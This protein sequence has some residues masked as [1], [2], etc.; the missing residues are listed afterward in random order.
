MCARRIAVLLPPSKG[1]AN[2]DTAASSLSYAQTL[3]GKDPLARPRRVVLDALL[4]SHATL[5][6]P[7]KMRLYGVGETAVVAAGQQHAALS[8]A[9]TRPARE[10][11][12]GVIYTN[13]GLGN[14][15]Y[16]HP[17]VAVLIVSAVLGVVELDT[18]IPNY[19]VEFGAQLPPVG[20]LSRFWA[21]ACRDYLLQ[22][23]AGLEVWNLLPNEH[24]GILGGC[25]E[26]LN[27]IDVRFVTPSGARANTA[28]SKVAKGHMVATLR[29][30]GPLDSK[31]FAALNPLAPGW[32][33][34]AEGQTLTGVCHL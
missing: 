7:A 17:D 19:R 27:L 34:N 20:S 28:R 15:T 14:R 4:A 24:R 3:T 2:D 25:A 32:T 5:S 1:K 29:R 11:Y 26:E 30:E 31:A 22:R 8:D 21:A 18:P 9:P 12:R 33:F 10:R 13:A 23:L 6:T 16:D